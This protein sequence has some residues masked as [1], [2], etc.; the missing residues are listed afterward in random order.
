MKVELRIW[1]YFIILLTPGSLRPLLSI[2]QSMRLLHLTRLWTALSASFQAI[3]TL[4]SSAKVSPLSCFSACL[5]LFP[6]GFHV[7]A[8]YFFIIFVQWIFTSFSATE[9]TVVLFL[10]R[11]SPSLHM[12]HLSFVLFFFNLFLLAVSYYIRD[13][14]SWIFLGAM[15]APEVKILWAHKKIYEPTRKSMSPQWTWWNKV[16]FS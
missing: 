12:S 3:S 7:R 10:L 15:W 6:W 11:C 13:A 9:K 8:C 14:T 16:Y 4:C 2:G 1:I 5:L